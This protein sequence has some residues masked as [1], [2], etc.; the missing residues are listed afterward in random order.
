MGRTVEI[1]RLQ[2]V[3]QNDEIPQTSERRAHLS[4]RFEAHG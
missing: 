3:E 4:A 1:P 2:L